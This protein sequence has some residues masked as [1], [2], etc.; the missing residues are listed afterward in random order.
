MASAFDRTCKLALET[1]ADTCDARRQDF[2][3]GG[4][5]ALEK[6]D[7]FV[8]D[9]QRSIRFERTGFAFG[10]TKTTA[11]IGT[12][13]LGILCIVIHNSISNCLN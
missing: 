11:V 7:I 6:L 3:A 1:S 8:I 2:A 9:R 12:G 4:E 10:T 5:E 13:A